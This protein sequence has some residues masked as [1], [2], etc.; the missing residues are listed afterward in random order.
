MWHHE[1]PLN[2]TFTEK[3]VVA[4]K[5]KKNFRSCYNISLPNCRN[6]NNNDKPKVK[7]SSSLP[8]EV[9]CS[10]YINYILP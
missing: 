4:K 7:I 5:K 10:L 6:I 3:N 2:L 9:E 8:V 1:R